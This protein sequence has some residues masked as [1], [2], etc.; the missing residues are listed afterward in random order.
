MKKNILKSALALSALLSSAAALAQPYIGAAVGRSD[1]QVDCA[2]ATA[3]DTTDTAFKLY[4]GYMFNENF[5]IEGELFDLGTA[6]ATLS[7]P[8]IGTAAVEGRARGLGVYGI[9]ALPID[10]ISVFAKAGLAYTQSKLDV[11]GALASSDDQWKFAPA[12]GVGASYAFTPRLGARV[13]WERLRVEYPGGQKE[14][15][16]LI[17]AGVTYRF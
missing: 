2:G 6:K 15:T 3:C 13:E 17:S 11:R 5:G 8:G 16:D 14:D 9:A 12:I 10:Q 7:M 4:G 1:Y